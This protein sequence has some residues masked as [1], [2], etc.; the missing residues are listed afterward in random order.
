IP[1]WAP[2]TT[3]PRTSRPSQP[4]ASSPAA[5]PRMP[6]T[7]LGRDARNPGNVRDVGD[8]TIRVLLAS[9]ATSTRISSSGGVLFTDRNGSLVA[10]AGPSETWRV[11]HDGW[12]VR[13]VRPDG[14][15]TVWT[16]A[17]L[18]ARPIGDALL[19]VADKPYRGDFSF[20]GTDSTLQVVNVVKID[21]YLRG[22][23]PLEIGTR[24]QGDSAAVQEQ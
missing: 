6:A 20:Y 9:P 18:V 17:P 19:S 16:D 15:G 4:P 22:V 24:S 21:D 1:V 23:V 8:V 2:D 11:E 10:R 14:V 7:V 13:A 12:R 3:P 5:T